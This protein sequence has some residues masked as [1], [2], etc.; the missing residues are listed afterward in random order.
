MPSRTRQVDVVEQNLPVAVR[1]VQMSVHRHHAKDFH[2]RGIERRG[3][4]RVT[5]MA[6]RD[7][8]GGLTRHTIESE[9]FKESGIR[10]VIADRGCRKKGTRPSVARTGSKSSQPEGCSRSGVNRSLCFLLRVERCRQDIGSD[11]TA[12]NP[13]AC[14]SLLFSMSIQELIQYADLLGSVRGRPAMHRAAP[15]RSPLF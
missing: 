10:R 8:V 13:V 11:G 2:P 4:H 9:R 5:L 3:D 15:G 1:L 14:P 7:G 6:L 12:A